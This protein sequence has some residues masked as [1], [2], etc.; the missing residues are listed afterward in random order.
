MNWKS[1]VNGR[2][3]IM[4][5]EEDWKLGPMSREAASIAFGFVSKWPESK[6]C[7]VNPYSG[8]FLEDEADASKCIDKLSKKF[9]GMDK[10]VIRC[11]VRSGFLSAMETRKG[12][13]GI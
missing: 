10:S 7:S 2:G 9:V 12:G 11:L 13:N 4:K 5:K 3:F 8:S 6:L 1:Y